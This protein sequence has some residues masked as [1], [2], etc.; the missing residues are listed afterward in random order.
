MFLK[1]KIHILFRA[2]WTVFIIKHDLFIFLSWFR[3]DDFFTEES[4]IMDKQ[5]VF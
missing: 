3:Q 1:N 5:L 2:V 4:N